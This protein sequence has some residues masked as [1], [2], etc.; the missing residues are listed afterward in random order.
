[1]DVAIVRTDT[2][3]FE[4]IGKPFEQ[5]TDHFK[6]LSQSVQMDNKWIT[7]AYPLETDNC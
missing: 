3:F 6:W 5:L 2:K 7:N 4:R 1:M